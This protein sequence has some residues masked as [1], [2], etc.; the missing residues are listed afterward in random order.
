MIKMENNDKFKKINTINCTC[1]Y[2]NDI[3]K[4]EDFDID[5]ILIDKKS[6]ENFLIH[7]ISYKNLIGVKPLRIRLDKIDGFIRVYDRTRYL[8]LFWSEKIWFHLK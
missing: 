8:V 2:T 6:C 4:F 5:N 1:C 3:T 7:N